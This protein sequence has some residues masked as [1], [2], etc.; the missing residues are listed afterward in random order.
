MLLH[1]GDRPGTAPAGAGQ[2]ER[3]GAGESAMAR[4]TVQAGIDAFAQIVQRAHSPLANRKELI[5]SREER[6]VKSEEGRERRESA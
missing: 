1:D 2:C 3:L 6:G 4:K 5:E